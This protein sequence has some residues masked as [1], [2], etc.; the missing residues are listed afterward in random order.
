[1]VNRGG[2][3]LGNSIAGNY[4]EL[5][6]ALGSEL[7]LEVRGEA[8]GGQEAGQL[9]VT[10]SG[11]VGCCLSSMI[12]VVPAGCSLWLPAT[13]PARHI[14][15]LGETQVMAFWLQR[16]F[17]T[18]TNPGTIVTTP[19]LLETVRR[20]LDER[21]TRLDPSYQHLIQ[22]VLWH[23]LMTLTT[24]PFSL[25]LPSSPFLIKIANVIV[26]ECRHR[27]TLKQLCDRFDV[28][29]SVVYQGFLQETGL[30]FG[31]WR[32]RLQ[33]LLALQRLAAGRPVQSVALEL[34]FGSSGGLIELF[35]R[36]LGMPPAQ[37]VKRKLRSAAP[38]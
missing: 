27:L 8:P 9:L 35:K 28:N 3:S 17:P 25:T 1:M 31:Q 10:L 21:Y 19:F 2:S 12:F 34:G 15:A 24:L 22:E 30:K 11:T 16:P 33:L 5:I 29:A 32:Q 7:R 23:E 20:L 4:P 38:R 13:E 36:T 6:A 18:S 26:S 14:A 37:F